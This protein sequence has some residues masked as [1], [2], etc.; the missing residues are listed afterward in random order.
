MTIS[1]CS[2]LW[3]SSHSGSRAWERGAS[4]WGPRF[5]VGSSRYAHWLG[6]P[7]LKSSTVA[8]EPLVERLRSSRGSSRWS[9]F[10]GVARANPAW[11]AAEPLEE[12]LTPSRV[13]SSLLM[14]TLL[15]RSNRVVRYGRGA[16]GFN[17]LISYRGRDILSVERASP[18]PSRAPIG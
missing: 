6:Y 10:R 1:P 5:T 14:E 16:L 4:S 12:S 8:P 17:W 18:T 11:V 3:S 15:L 7:L 13:L 2:R 9:S